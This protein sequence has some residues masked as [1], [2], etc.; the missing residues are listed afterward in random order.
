MHL[1]PATGVFQQ[2]FAFPDATSQERFDRGRNVLNRVWLVTPS[3]DTL[4]DGLGPLFNQTS[5][6]ACHQANGRGRVPD[7]GEGPMVSALVRLS[8]REHGKVVP[9]PVYGEQLNEQGIPGVAGEGRAEVRYT[10]RTVVFGAAQSAVR[11]EPDAGGGASI[12]LRQPHVTFRDL[13]YGPLGRDTMTSLRV[14]PAIFGL[15]LLELV[16]EV[17]LLE[18]VDP[19]DVNHDGVS[20]RPNLIADDHG[21]AA[22]VGRFG[23]KA[24]SPD[25]LAQVAS[26][27]REDLGLTTAQMAESSCT[28]AETACMQAPSGGDPELAQF[29]MDNLLTYL[30]YIAPPEPRNVADADV[31]R[32]AQLFRAVG[33]PACHRETLT[34]G[35]RARDPDLARRQFH[36]YTDLLLH[37]MGP[38]LADARPD[39]EASGT[40]WRTAPLWGLGLVQLAEPKAGFLHD[41]RARTIVEAVLWHDGEARGARDHFTKLSATDRASLLA[42]L[43]SL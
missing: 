39:H 4:H 31:Q 5:C 18:Y 13:R 43:N 14:A 16:P 22:V 8:V 30:M 27:F 34:T 35:E 7:S 19:D 15:G 23:W 37:D 10:T 25:L 24:N 3:S 36:P 6:I 40:E 33:C 2:A 28:R 17:E 38:G 21:G 41:G 1:P 32:G 26:A 12:E 11:K 20:G 42:F 29:M 9:H